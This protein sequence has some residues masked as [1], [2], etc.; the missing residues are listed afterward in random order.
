MI[1]QTLTPT[2]H[3]IAVPEHKAL[4]IGT[5]NCILRAVAL[6]KGVDRESILKEI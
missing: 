2:P 5:L 4:R 6:H 3:R 1:L